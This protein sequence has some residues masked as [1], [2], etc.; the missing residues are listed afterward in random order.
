MSDP[1]SATA[2]II[3]VLQMTATVTQYLKDVKDGADDRMRLRDE[4]RGTV[5]LLEMLKD[6]LEDAD[7]SKKWWNAIQWLNIPDGP[8]Q[9][10]KKT[11][12]LL[13]AKLMPARGMQKV[14]HIIKWPFDKTDVDTLLR[15]IERQ[16]SLFSL[17]I[18]NDHM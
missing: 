15:A 17:A 16:K 5:C 7:S 3:A 18:H 4:L 12:E 13:I 6:R 11:L 1:L 14:V 2:S 10:F 8:L 9:L